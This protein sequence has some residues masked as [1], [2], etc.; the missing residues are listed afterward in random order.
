[1]STVSDTRQLAVLLGDSHVFW[2]G[3]FVADYMVRFGSG[4]DFQGT[5]CCI[6]FSGFRGGTV[7][8]VGSLGRLTS[9]L[10]AEVTRIVVLALGGNDLRKVL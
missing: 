1:M 10:T 3:R 6:R 4:P 5:D 9:L 7:A 8:S 2:L